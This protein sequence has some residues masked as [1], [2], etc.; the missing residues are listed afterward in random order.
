MRKSAQ[1]GIEVRKPR[2]PEG[3]LRSR[4]MRR[5]RAIADRAARKLM[6]SGR[7]LSSVDIDKLYAGPLGLPQ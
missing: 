5:L 1:P 2:D 6:K 7:P 3:K 4:R